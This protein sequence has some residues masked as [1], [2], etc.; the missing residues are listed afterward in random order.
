MWVA[1]WWLAGFVLFV[2]LERERRRLDGKCNQ[3]NRSLEVSME[4]SEFENRLR[5]AHE[6]KVES[7]E[8]T[9]KELQVQIGNRD[10][11]IKGFE[12]TVS[13]RDAE[14]QKLIDASIRREAVIEGLQRQLTD[15][16]QK[17]NGTQAR[18]N[19]LQKELDELRQEIAELQELRD[20]ELRRA[21]EEKSRQAKFQSEQL[22]RL[23]EARRNMLAAVGGIEAAHGGFP[24]RN[25]DDDDLEEEAAE[26]DPSEFID[27]KALE[28]D[29]E[30]IISE[31]IQSR[32]A[33]IQKLEQELDRALSS[34]EAIAV[35]LDCLKKRSEEVVRERDCFARDLHKLNAELEPYREIIDSGSVMSVNDDYAFTSDPGDWNSITISLSSRLIHG[36]KRAQ[37]AA[38]VMNRDTSPNGP[39]AGHLQALA[40]LLIQTLERKYPLLATWGGREAVE[41]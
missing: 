10:Q 30:R 1:M 4:E 20:K 11:I 39:T 26:V 27:G 24:V 21:A 9:V 37:P 38:T 36:N 14:K 8:M 13:R 23:R 33:L 22:N 40:D 7:L 5:R 18:A 35:E 15:A 25:A 31:A 3:L 29:R 6:A 41:A 28:L 32:D 2:C 16:Q 12:G 19:Q 34:R 17:A